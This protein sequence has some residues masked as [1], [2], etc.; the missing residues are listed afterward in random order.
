MPTYN[1]ILK[2]ISAAVK[3]FN[4]NIP[5]AQKDMFD[6]ISEQVQRLDLTPDGNVRTTA[7]NLSILTS[8][9]AKMIRVL[10]TPEYREAVKEF[11]QSF[12]EVTK[13]QNLYWKEQESKFKPRKVLTAL[14]KQAISDTVNQLTESGIG[15]NVGERITE[16]LKASI[17]SGGSYKKLTASLRDGLLNTEQKGYLD[18]YAKQVTIDSLNQYSRQYNKIISSDLG[19]TWFKYD[20]TDIDTTRHWCDAM[21]DQPYFHI[22]ELPRL[23][24][25]EGLYYSKEGVKTKV[26]VNPKTNLWY[27]AIPGTDV[28]TVFVNAG[29]YNCKHS[30]R[31]VNERQVPADVVAKAKAT[32][33]YISWVKN[34]S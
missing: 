6:A 13:L 2:T 34:N 30:I 11:A 31:P 1:D 27:G 12:N 28:S 24:R 17:T 33:E 29:G 8:I 26:E 7:K 25:S 19:Y 9:K 15:V 20:N 14:R 3:K 22:S 32:P 10:V 18:R 5:K 23:L 16:M 4:R 21:T